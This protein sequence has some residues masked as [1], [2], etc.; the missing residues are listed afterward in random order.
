MLAECQITAQLLLQPVLDSLKGIFLFLCF[1]II[2]FLWLCSIC[3]WLL[4]GIELVGVSTLLQELGSQEKKKKL[5]LGPSFDRRVTW[6]AP[7]AFVF[8]KD[9]HVTFGHF[10]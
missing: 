9:A 2:L 8:P 6:V 7:E 10:Y 1:M 3:V 4:Q 5:H